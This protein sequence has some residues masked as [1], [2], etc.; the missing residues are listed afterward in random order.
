ML[1]PNV[2]RRRTRH[3]DSCRLSV[4]DHASGSWQT[5]NVKKRLRLDGSPLGGLRLEH[6]LP[7]SLA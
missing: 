6:C 4:L 1:L 2:K 7:L 5:R 3:R